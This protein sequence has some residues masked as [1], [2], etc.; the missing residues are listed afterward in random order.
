MSVILEADETICSCGCSQIRLDTGPLPG[1]DRIVQDRTGHLISQDL[2]ARLKGTTFIF[3]MPSSSLLVVSGLDGTCYTH[4]DFVD[5]AILTHTP[6]GYPKI[7]RFSARINPSSS[8]AFI[9]I[10]RRKSL[11]KYNFLNIFPSHFLFL[12]LS[13][14]L[15]L[16]TRICVRLKIH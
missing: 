6:R 15:R 5:I 2:L 3:Q 7:I 12:Q 16:R 4:A 13:P 14:S 10:F 8:C 9:I 11:K 1:Q